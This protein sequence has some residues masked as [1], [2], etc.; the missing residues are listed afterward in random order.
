MRTLPLFRSFTSALF[1]SSF[2]FFFLSLVRGQ[3]AG[4]KDWFQLCTS[5]EDNCLIGSVKTGEQYANDV[6]HKYRVKYPT[7][8]SGRGRQLAPRSGTISITLH[9]LII[10]LIKISDHNDYLSDEY[11][12]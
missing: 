2:V 1:F 7:L 5:T 12:M 4:K 10:C 11:L 8:L 3:C 9:Q 6:C